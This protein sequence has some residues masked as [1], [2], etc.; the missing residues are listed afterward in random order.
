MTDKDKLINRLQAYSATL[1]VIL[2][3]ILMHN[4]RNHANPDTTPTP[5]TAIHQTLASQ[6]NNQ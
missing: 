2:F 5:Q 6:T 4:L 3:L 1:T